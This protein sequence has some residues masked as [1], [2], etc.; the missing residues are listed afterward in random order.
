MAYTEMLSLTCADE[1]SKIPTRNKKTF[2][3]SR[4]LYSL[5]MISVK[6]PPNINVA[7][8]KPGIEINGGLVTQ[9]Y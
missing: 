8:S 1:V 7:H 2:N 3:A 6:R 5:V 4:M 9:A